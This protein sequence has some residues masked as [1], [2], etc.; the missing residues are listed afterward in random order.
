MTI[1]LA[2]VCIPSAWKAIVPASS[3]FRLD[4]V[5]ECFFP[6]AVM[7][8]LP[9]DFNLCPSL[10]QEPST[11]AW[12]SSTSRV[13]VSVSCALVSVKLL[14]TWI[15]FTEGGR[16]ALTCLRECVHGNLTQKQQWTLH[17]YNIKK[18]NIWVLLSTLS[19]HWVLS[20]SVSQEYMPRSACVT[21]LKTRACLAPTT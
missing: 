7:R 21:L 3:I 19:L 9:P 1:S 10:V 6:K 4:K 16:R 17:N 15:F 12:L 5:T 8:Q 13:T 20:S 11:S 2:D 14:M 18:G